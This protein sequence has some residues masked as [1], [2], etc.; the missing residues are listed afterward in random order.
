MTREKGFLAWFASNHV[1]S[2]ILMVALLASG[3]MVAN[4]ILIEVFPEIE[5]G[6]ITIRVPYLGAAPSEVEEGVCVRVEEAV[7][8]IDGIKR[9][10]S[11]ALEGMGI[12]T[13]ELQED[14]D[15]R[16]ALDDIKNE[17]D[18]IETFPE[19]TEKPVI[20]EITNRSQVITVVLHGDVPES[21]LKYLAERVRDDL[22]GMD[23]ISQ[24]E[25]AG[26]RNFEI[27]I[28][29]SE[30]NL[31]RY[32]LTFDDV[33]RAV[34]TGSL[35][36][37]GGSMKT[38]GGEI[39]IRAKGQRYR[40]HE[41][42]E[43]VLLS[44]PDG[45]R[46]LLGDVATVRDGFEDSDVASRFDGSSAASILVY[47]V[48]QQGALDV[49]RTVKQ[50][51]KDIRPRLPAGVDID[52][53]EDRSLILRSRLEL[54]TRNGLLGL[55][56]VFFCLGTFLQLRLAFWTTM[57]IPISFL[58]GLGIVYFLG[59]SI[60][61]V[62][63]FAFIVVLGIVVDDAIVVG[64]NIFEYQQQGLSPMEAAVRGVR[65]MAV[66]VV[67]AVLTTV[68]AFLPLLL[69]KG[70][71]G[72]IMRQIPMVV[73]SVLLISLVEALLILPA[74]LSGSRKTGTPR[75]MLRGQRII[76]DGLDRFI[77]SAYRGSLEFALR[78]RYMTVSMALAL[79]AI[80]VGMIVGGFVKFTF[81]SQIDSDNMVADLTMPQGTPMEETEALVRKLEDSARQVVREFEGQLP[82]GA[83]PLLVHIS[84]S[85]GEQ[86]RA[87][88][89]G[90]PNAGS[91]VSSS[92]S[93]LAEVNVELLNSEERGDISASEM[94]DRWREIV[95]EVAGASS[96]T[97]SAALFSA[98]DDI[99]VA[100]SHQDFDT[101]LEASDRLK[102]MVAEFPGTGD[103][104]D[105]FLAG[106]R[107]LKLQLKP[108][109]RTL[110]LTLGELARQVRQGYYGE[111]A[112]RIQRGR[113]DIRVMVRYPEEARQTLA[114]LDR[115]RVRLPGGIEIPFHN[116]AIVEEGQGYAAI[117][118]TDRRRV[119]T[120]SAKVNE[121][122]A[123]ANEINRVIRSQLLPALKQDYPGLS[124]SFEG[125][126]RE[127]A[128]TMGSLFVNFLYAQL[129]IF[130]LLA[131]PFRSY[132][133]PLIVMSAI[134]FGIVGAVLGHFVMGYDLSMLSGFGIVA[135]TGVVVND[136]L[137]MIDLIN[138]MR[139]EGV[140]LHHVVRDSGVRRFR[141]I[142][143][144]TLTTFLGLTPMILEKSLQA[145]FLVPMAI[146][147][148]FGVVFATAITL[149]LVP[150]LYMILEDIKG[151]FRRGAD[152]V[153]SVVSATAEEP[154]AG[155]E[156]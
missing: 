127:Q 149:I 42:E 55:I 65:E 132:F 25:F 74:H 86:P 79:L 154:E 100:L 18:R 92:G 21:S 22:T 67:F 108:E 122:V 107:E 73:C 54:L 72:Q 134:P 140:D 98:G 40:G 2:N 59:V 90:G 80:I 112:Q 136:S 75:W 123:N 52:T 124:F 76:Q 150:C 138:R 101:L 24:A 9:L 153:V 143:L 146:S 102:S 31:R 47:R 83:G 12:V 85:L 71:F 117:D 91:G 135:L 7:A 63:L 78:N 109:G 30:E 57:G 14:A 45:T 11:V 131:V 118:R 147:L 34:R 19:Q 5:T 36:L 128:E 155:S 99:S 95:G 60:N 139:E 115:M 129:A 6:R 82:A 33:A 151:L 28:E 3:I 142:L 103:V 81:L 38:E 94:A 37:P 17:V 120:I 97:F 64:E 26:I 114:S 46:V 53:W 58:G 89:G 104:A 113:D 39:L 4:R 121:D 119:V 62:S 96:L 13:V 29:V 23:N 8:G 48:G 145:R 111:E 1:A 43:I 110:G 20:S 35:D 10:Q 105:S 50:Y 41:F 61:M 68:A 125:A 130:C 87:A 116:V 51:V 70:N 84:S 148:G 44:R 144:T 156:A 88:G 32:G 152:V 106:K 66:P 69:T 93:H 141:P 77:N 133:Q 137:I 126:Q 15:T 49:A 56:L 27:S 16:K